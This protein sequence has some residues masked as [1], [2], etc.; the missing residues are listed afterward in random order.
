MKRLTAALFDLY[1]TLVY[2]DRLRHEDKV[3]ACA[4]ICNVEPQAYSEVWRSL[5]VESN[6]GVFPNTEDRVMAVV[7]RL[8]VPERSGLIETL[9]DYEHRFLEVG[10]ILFDDAITTLVSLRQH[11]LKLG[12][13]TNASPSV[14]IVLRKHE[15]DKYIDCITISCEVGYRKPDANIYKFA[16]NSLEV[17]AGDC[18]FVGDGNDGELDGAHNLGIVTV[19]VRRN[20]PK[21]MQMKDSSIDNVDFTVA[22]LAE[23]VNLID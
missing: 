7:K 13:V 19:W 18:M 14:R 10:T 12:L 16:M 9:T 15:L 8:G 4:R 20:L 3:N 11:G 2:A 6:L 5:V 21:Y 22:S 23:V 1:D 17:E